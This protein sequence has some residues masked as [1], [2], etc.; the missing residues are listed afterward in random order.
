MKRLFVLA[1]I[2][3]GVVTFGQTSRIYSTIIGQEVVYNIPI[4]LAKATT[5]YSA[6]FLL[7]QYLPFDSTTYFPVLWQSND[8]VQV[9]IYLQVKND[10]STIS[11]SYDGSWQ[12]VCT[13][14][15]NQ[16]NAG[17][18]TLYVMNV[19]QRGAVP[20]GVTD[21]VTMAGKIGNKGRIKVVFGNPTTVGN[22]GQFRL[23]TVLPKIK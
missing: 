15:T 20:S 10:R 7:D 18:D 2:L 9:T 17:N 4:T 8:T 1:V 19:F 16:L 5:S 11:D 22:S 6:E 12:N 13:L 3:F 23:W 14:V 21:K